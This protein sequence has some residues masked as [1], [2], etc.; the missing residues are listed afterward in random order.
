MDNLPIPGSATGARIYAPGHDPV[1]SRMADVVP[2]VAADC[3]MSAPHG[4]VWFAPASVSINAALFRFSK[5]RATTERADSP[6]LLSSRPLQVTL[7]PL[8]ENAQHGS[9]PLA[10]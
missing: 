5:A 8:P 10:G 1:V 9:S 7:S 3:R 6:W 2:A 4:Q